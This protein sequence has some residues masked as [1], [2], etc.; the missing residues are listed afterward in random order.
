MSNIPLSL[1]LLQMIASRNAS[2]EA[3]VPCS[4]TQPHRTCR[5]IWRRH[6]ADPSDCSTWCHQATLPILMLPC[7]CRPIH[8]YSRKYSSNDR[9][10]HRQSVSLSNTLSPSLARSHSCI[11]FSVFGAQ[12]P[13]HL[14]APAPIHPM[15]IAH[16]QQS[17]FIGQQ[18]MMST[19]PASIAMSLGR[20]SPAMSQEQ[21]IAQSMSTS[22]SQVSPIYQLT[23]YRG[24]TL[25]LS[26]SLCVGQPAVCNG[27]HPDVSDAQTRQ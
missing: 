7:R 26:S 5:L 20:N 17:P 27:L 21:L 3:W 24:L 16:M 10:C 19:S 13:V 14:L 2:K 6:L 8:C 18:R 9:N 23:M 22:A 4:D 11:S 1:T 25:H 12:P 15:G